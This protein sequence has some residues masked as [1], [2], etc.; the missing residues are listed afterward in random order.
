MLS[1]ASRNLK[2][3]D[4]G[5][6]IVKLLRA[7][8]RYEQNLMKLII[9]LVLMFAIPAFGQNLDTERRAGQERAA[10]VA[11]TNLIRLVEGKA[12]HVVNSTNWI[13]LPTQ[14][15]RGKFSRPSSDGPIFTLEKHM[16]GQR[17]GPTW[18]EFDREV[19]VKNYPVTKLIAGDAMPAIRVMPIRTTPEGIAVY[20]YGTLPK[21]QTNAPAKK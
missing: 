20:D 17:F 8:E 9:L 14:F 21:P 3:G 1:V 13:T 12:Y 10:K 4:D 6:Y 19:I 16:G 15:Q 5:D 2:I 11:G 18:Y 7:V